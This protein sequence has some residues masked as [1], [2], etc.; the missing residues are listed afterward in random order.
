MGGTIPFGPRPGEAP[1]HGHRAM[2]ADRS[3]RTG[4]GG[5]IGRVTD[6]GPRSSPIGGQP[7]DARPVALT[8]R[9]WQAVG[10]LAQH[11]AVTTEAMVER[12]AWRALAGSLSRA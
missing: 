12:L 8:P 5:I 11:H 2:P 9:V 1:D 7:L 6:P 3:T 10:A 4:E